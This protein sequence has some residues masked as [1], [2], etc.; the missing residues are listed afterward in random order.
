MHREA[1]CSATV[2]GPLWLSVLVSSVHGQGENALAPMAFWLPGPKSL[3][4]PEL[5]PNIFGHRMEPCYPGAAGADDSCAFEGPFNTRE[6]CV[7]PPV[8]GSVAFCLLLSKFGSYLVGQPADALP[9]SKMRVQ[10]ASTPQALLFSGFADR[11]LE[12]RGYFDVARWVCQACAEEQDLAEWPR[13]RCAGFDYG[14]TTTVTLTTR[15]GTLT[16]T[17]STSSTGTN[18]TTFHTT[19]TST[20]IIN[21]TTTIPAEMPQAVIE[22]SFVASIVLAAFV[23]FCVLFGRQG[24]RALIPDEV[25][26]QLEGYVQV[27]ASVQIAKRRRRKLE[28]AAERRR[29]AAAV[30]CGG[31][32]GT[33]DMLGEKQVITNM[34]VFWKDR[35]VTDIRPRGKRAFLMMS[36]NR[37]YMARLDDSGERLVW[38]DGSVW[39]RMSERTPREEG[40]AE[41]APL[42]QDT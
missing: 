27:A 31:Y 8:L 18:T 26:R 11:H 41:D 24:A 28:E 14:T 23:C 29:G 25:A 5:A 32:E 7:K 34:K 6:L 20:N 13:M 4:S 22:M 9:S 2:V 17:T 19:T 38:D 15:T 42:L 33:W 37:E 30:A 16:R 40:E 39:V 21:M 35:K 10:C 3:R 1:R 36:N 12:D